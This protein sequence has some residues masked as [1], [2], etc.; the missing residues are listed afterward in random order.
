V[1]VYRHDRRRRVVLAMLIVTSLA[2]ISLDERG[3]HVVSTAR[4]AAQDVVAPV[5]HLVDDVVNPISDWFDGL[6]RASELRDEN[7][8]LRRELSQMKA[9]VAAA[10]VAQ[11]RIK[12]LSALADIPTVDDHDGV[13]AQVVAQSSGNFSRT[14]RLD[15]GSLAGIEKDMP[16]VAPGGA[17][18]GRVASVSRDSSVIQRIDDR[19]FGVGALL[20]TKDG[21]Q[22]PQGFALGQPDSTLLEFSVGDR[23]AATVVMHKGDIAYTLGLTGEHYPK[24]LPVGTVTRTVEAGGSVARTASLRPIVDLDGLDLVKV[25]RYVPAPIGAP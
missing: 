13:V 14:F 21:V 12:E 24:G 9:E 22:G 8:T 19:N 3:A 20:V 23:S 17:L 5:Q 18:V 16:V 4:T 11:A 6:G 2:L 25:I 1:V 15:K 7:T 10:K